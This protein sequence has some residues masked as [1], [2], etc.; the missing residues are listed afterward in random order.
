M[1]VCVMAGQG[2]VYEV[3]HMG[4]LEG[5]LTWWSIHLVINN[6]FGFNTNFR[7]GRSRTY[8]TDIAKVTLSPVF[9]VNGDDA[10]ALVHAIQMAME[11][12]QQ[13]HNDVFIDILCYRRFGHNESDEPR[14]TQPTLYKAIA[15][16]PNPREIYVRKLID[17]GDR[18]STRL[19]SS[20]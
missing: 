20:Q 9:Q 18:K 4:K 11:Y 5:Y 14:F 10:E 3:I 8:C 12:R 6:Q 1:C 17:Q 15:A 19:N 2:V 16:H 13:F 7:D